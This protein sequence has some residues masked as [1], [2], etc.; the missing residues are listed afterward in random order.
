[1]ASARAPAGPARACAVSRSPRRPPGGTGLLV[2]LLGLALVTV[3]PAA[4]QPPTLDTARAL[5]RTG[6]LDEAVA[7]YT[8]VIEARP[9]D[10]D[11]R[12]ERA[13][14]LGWLHHDAEALADYDY[15]LA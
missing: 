13:R 11:A 10:L 15:I 12:M 2:L 6:R 7:A 8:R 14:I 9:K 3:R 4:A 1:G 5:A